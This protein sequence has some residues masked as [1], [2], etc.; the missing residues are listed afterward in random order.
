MESPRSHSS[1]AQQSTQVQSAAL[2]FVGRG[3]AIALGFVLLSSPPALQGWAGGDTRAFVLATIALAVVNVLLVWSW[4]ERPADPL[5]PEALAEGARRTLPNAALIVLVAIG[6]V[7]LVVTA[8]HAWLYQILTIPHDPQRADM[9]IVV[10]QGLQRMLQGRN[11]YTI[12]HVPW[13]APLPY[14][15]ML[16]APYAIPMAL[17][18]DVRFLTVAGELFLPMACAIG[19]VVSAARRRLAASAACLVM[20]AAICLNPD[21]ERFASIGHTP[22]YWP[23]LA[24]FVWLTARGRWYAAA[25]ALGLLVVARTTM[26]AIVPVLLMAVWWNKRERFFGTLVLV[27]LA[28]IV[29][30]LPFAIWDPRALSYALYSSYQN[31][32]K[33]FVWTSTT[34]AQHTIGITG[35]MLSNGLQRFVDAGQ[36]FVML[37]VYFACWRA[38]RRGCPPAPWMGLALLTFSMTTLW[39]VTYVY[40]DVLLLL[41]AA[42]LAGAV[43]LDAG[44]LPSLARSWTATA[45]ATAAL[46]IGS[47]ALMLPDLRVVDAGTADGRAFLRSGFAGDE[48]EGDRTFARVVGRHASIVLPRRAVRGAVIDVV[49]RPGLAATSSAQLMSALLNG[50]SVGTVVLAP[51]W[52][53]I[54]LAAPAQA[55]RIGV[56]ELELFLASGGSAADAG[57]NSNPQLSVAIDR[58]TVRSR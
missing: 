15:P 6:A 13:D 46:V 47:A 21:L 52:N 30:F 57:A 25:I 24:L 17:H 8:C 44:Q 1:I 34:W 31:V 18:A 39:P 36:A 58:V 53:Q 32:I 4:T 37:A 16:W 27:T 38:M 54:S 22:V 29:P 3:L 19:A 26:A 33:G 2:P 48:R 5:R 51:G 10:Q 40:F 49:C 43:S 9:L 7:W 42:V 28:A 20:L 45:I 41:A 56:N 55:W 50:M 12:Y 14:G 35:V 23:L 11:P